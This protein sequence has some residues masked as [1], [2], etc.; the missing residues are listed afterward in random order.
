M[1]KGI[2]TEQELLASFGVGSLSFTPY[3]VT[4]KQGKISGEYTGEWYFDSASAHWYA[5]YP[6]GFRDDLYFSFT[7]GELTCRRLIKN[8]SSEKIALTEAGFSILGIKAGDDPEQDFY[9]HAENSRVYATMTL[10]IDFDRLAPGG[11]DP[12]Y[13]DLNSYLSFVEVPVCTKRVGATPYQPFPAILIG[14]HK[15]THGL[16]HGTLEQRVFY[17]CYDLAHENGTVNMDVVSGFK[18][19]DALEVVPG[20][21]LVDRWYLG[22]TDHADDIEKI[23]ERYTEVL[24]TVLPPMYGATDANRH[25]GVWESWNDGNERNINEAMLLAEAEFVSKEFPTVKYI[26]LDD[27][28]WH[29]DDG[30]HG[31]GTAYEKDGGI[32][33]KKFPE[34]L[35]AYSDKVR[36][37][38]M[39]P[40]IWTGYNFTYGSQIAEEH[41]EWRAPYAWRYEVDYPGLKCGVVADPSIPEV[42]EYLAYAINTFCSDY[43]FNGIKLDFWSYVFD[44]SYPMMKYREHSGYE[45]RRW[46]LTEFRKNLPTD[47]YFQPGCDLVQANPFL[48]EFFTN[49]R[50]GL[51]IS[52]GEWEHVKTTFL[53]G[54]SCFATHIGDIYV[55]NSD[56]IGIPPGLNE[57]ERYFAVNYTLISRSMVELSG[58]LHSDCPPHWL[59]VLKKA[60][61]N[62]NNGQ[63]VHFARYDYRKK[64]GMP[65]EIWYIDTP[66]FSRTSGTEGMPVK[67]VA[68]FNLTEEERSIEF[69]QSDLKLPAGEY[70]LTDVWTGKQYPFVQEVEFKLPRHGSLLLAVS[71]T[72]ALQVFDA[73]IRLEKIS[74]TEKEISFAVDYAADAELFLNRKPVKILCNGVALEFVQKDDFTCFHLPEKGTLTIG[75]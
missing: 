15:S 24:R 48:G 64:N 72:D 7:D 35:R 61:C 56:S 44:T 26:Q 11:K 57:T 75:F 36:R 37:F 2:L 55:P 40:A 18:G 28:Y 27:G 73:N 65:P 10:P 50:Y 25:Y 70:I 4:E 1:K 33:R 46:L 38:G 59:K 8:V 3:L 66:H 9:Y 58:K 67:T 21:T 47:G 62:L 32:D 53:W 41:P 68:L 49:Y 52:S 5:E 74:A 51:D 34:G 30:A 71:R 63:D 29:R 54:T 42:R 17:H 60:M 45:W 22:T 14:N 23:F 16:V 31:L 39:V 43:N 12:K 69:S 19:I 13:P 6:E 20:R